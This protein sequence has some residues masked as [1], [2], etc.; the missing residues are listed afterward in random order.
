MMGKAGIVGYYHD[1]KP[2]RD[3]APISVANPSDK[4]WHDSR[5]LFTFTAG[6][7]NVAHVLVWASDCADALESLGEWTA[8][9]MPGYVDEIGP[10][11]D[12]PSC[13]TDPHECGCRIYTESGW[14]PNFDR[15]AVI[16]NPT[17]EQLLELHMGLPYRDRWVSPPL[18]TAGLPTHI[19]N[20]KGL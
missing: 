7:W 12:C 6:M 11:D 9:H 4:A 16:E 10:E 18:M 13:G 14:L 2:M 3:G 1:G 19:T 17:K 5:Y 20:A 8:E 15:A